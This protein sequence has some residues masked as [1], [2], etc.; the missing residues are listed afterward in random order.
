MNQCMS[1]SRVDDMHTLSDTSQEVFMIKFRGAFPKRNHTRFDANS[2]QL[3]AI[4]LVCAPRQLLEIDVF[5]D[6]HLSRVNFENAG[7]SRFVW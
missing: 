3:S 7:T 1:R 4:E 5:R 6:G 2:L